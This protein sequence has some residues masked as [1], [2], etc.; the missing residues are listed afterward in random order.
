MLAIILNKQI[1]KSFF[2]SYKKIDNN[3]KITLVQSC[4]Y[5]NKI[6]N[7]YLL[8]MLCTNIVVTNM[9]FN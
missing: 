6:G 9:Y 7:I 3:L 8:L 1:I 4:I 5:Y 2:Y